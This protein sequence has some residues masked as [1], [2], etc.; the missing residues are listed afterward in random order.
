MDVPEKIY[1][2]VE[3][4]PALLANVRNDFLVNRVH[5]LFHAIWILGCVVAQGTLGFVLEAD[6]VFFFSYRQSFYAE[7]PCIEQKSDVKMV[8]MAPP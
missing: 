5:V 6:E 2:G 8:K 4:S 3:R 7:K 1:F